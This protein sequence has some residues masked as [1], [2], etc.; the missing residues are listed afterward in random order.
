MRDIL[1]AAIVLGSIPFIL[2]KPYLGVLMYVWLSVMNPHRLTWGFAYDFSFAAVI[3]VVTLVSAL[4]SKDLKRPPLNSLTVALFLFVVWTGVTTGFALYP[5]ESYGR[6]TTMVKT[7]IMVFLIPMLFHRKDHLRQLI[8]VIVLSVAYYGTKGGVFILVT[9][10]ENRVWGPAGSYIE[11]NNA[12]AVAV[13]MIIPLMR[14]LQ[15]TTIH[16]SVRWG[17]TV[18]M[19]MCGVAVLGSYS[20]GALLAASAMVAFLWWKTRQKLS[21]LLL[22]VV[23]IPMALYFMPERWYERMD[24]IATYEQDSSAR[25][26]LNSWGAMFNIAKDR[27]IVGGGFEIATKEV[28]DKY[29]PDP[30]FPPQAAHSIYFQAMGEHGFVGLGLFLFLYLMFWRHAGALVRQTRGQPDFAWAHDF[31]LMIQVSLIGF[32]VGGA[33]LSLVNF[34]VPYYLI[35]AMVVARA[36]VDQELRAVVTAPTLTNLSKPLAGIATNRSPKPD[37]S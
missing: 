1:L 4:L 15:L 3:A 27:P 26:R 19:L 5:A 22:A 7:Q 20:R 33:F 35:G 31:G 2:R 10:G 11:D 9:G 13:I 32:A 17:L 29:S 18:M 6:W 36:L 16:R 30:S 24:T 23:A 21:L 14:Y 25:M 8:W 28:F 12:L 37:S 34:D